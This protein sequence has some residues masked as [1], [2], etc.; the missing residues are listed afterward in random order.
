MAC[1][2][3]ARYVVAVVV[4]EVSKVVRCGLPG[5]LSVEEVAAC[6]GEA[7]MEV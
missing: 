3:D 2:S 1:G 4:P 7:A 5:R 6:E